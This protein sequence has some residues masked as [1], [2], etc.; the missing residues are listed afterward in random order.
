MNWK[1]EEPAVADPW[2]RSV[3]YF[4]MFGMQPHFDFYYIGLFFFTS[5]PTAPL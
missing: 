3:F 4:V 1:L 5:F 2:E